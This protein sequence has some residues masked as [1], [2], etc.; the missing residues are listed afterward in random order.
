MAWSL[1]SPFFNYKTIYFNQMIDNG[2][3]CAEPFTNNYLKKN[4]ILLS[5]TS[6]L[7][8]IPIFL[9]FLPKSWTQEIASSFPAEE[10]EV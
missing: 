6:N 2:N 9:C 10:E 5:S 3:P 1:P 7:D 8:Q 4:S